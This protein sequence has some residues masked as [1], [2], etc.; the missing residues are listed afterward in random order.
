M[1]TR[2]TA[3]LFAAVLAFGAV[4]QVFLPLKA[5][6]Q[7]HSPHHADFYRHWMQ[8]GVHPPLSCC[9]ARIE[10]DGQVTGDCEPTQAK[11]VKGG[12]VA[13]LRQESRWVEIP[14]DKLIREPNPNIFDAHLCYNHG[15]VLCF[16]PPDTGG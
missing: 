7:D 9:N 13:W 10:K 15:R 4:V 1:N 2:A 12:W 11:I 16:K 14:D 5:R 3:T 8:P 6:A